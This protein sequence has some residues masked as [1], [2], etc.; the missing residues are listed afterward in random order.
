MQLLENKVK[1]K[2]LQTKADNKQRKLDAATQIAN[3]GYY[4]IARH[5]LA[6]K[7]N[8][9]LTPTLRQA[10]KGLLTRFRRLYLEL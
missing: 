1:F 9:P 4:K 2:V 10:E 7:R 3:S 6:V 8:E 5:G